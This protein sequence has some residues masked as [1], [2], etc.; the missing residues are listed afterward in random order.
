VCAVRLYACARACVY[1]IIYLY[2]ESGWYNVP[3]MVLNRGPGEEGIETIIQT[4][5]IIRA[6]I[7]FSRNIHSKLMVFIEIIVQNTN[8]L[9]FI[10]G[11]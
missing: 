11:M 6:A 9:T 1:N 3:T 2:Y 8:G 10:I 5:I 7:L 4:T